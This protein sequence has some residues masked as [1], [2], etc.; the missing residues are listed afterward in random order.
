[1]D[2]K[3]NSYLSSIHG[4]QDQFE[5]EYLLT[6]LEQMNN[7]NSNYERVQNSRGVPV[8][9]KDTGEPVY[10]CLPRE[11]IN[12]IKQIDLSKSYKI[13]AKAPLI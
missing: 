12:K 6:D 4:E 3:S 8:L 13:Q 2:Q 7:S 10:E 11:I 9:F 1:M 5:D